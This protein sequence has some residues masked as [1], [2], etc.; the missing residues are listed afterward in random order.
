V[1]AQI[2][3]TRPG[4]LRNLRVIRTGRDDGS[5]IANVNAVVDGFVQQGFSAI[6]YYDVDG[7]VIARSGE[8]VRAPAIA[9]TLG[10]PHKAEL[11]W[12]GGYLMRHRIA[13]RD[14]SGDVGTGL[15]EQPLSVLNRVML[16]TPRL[17]ATAEIFQPVRE[18]LQLVAGLLLLLVAVGT[19][20]LRL[21]VRPLVT[22]LIDIGSHA[23][24]QEQRTKE[25]LDSAPD[26]IIIVNRDGRIVLVNS[27]TEKLFG[28]SRQE[29]LDQK[30]E[31][32][33]P[34]RYRQRHP[35]H[36]DG[37]FA[38]PRVRPMG[39]GLELYGR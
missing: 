13:L 14:T 10:T 39:V 36:R 7:K 11:L 33:L 19:V 4:V 8:F 26:A 16:D 2:A 24:R 3:A 27:Q 20:L 30:I 35:G 15:A 18:Q 29:L 23:R 31:M 1:T 21:Q 37:F 28:Y 38:D 34:E 25:L 6:A 17:G 5:N 9:V 12:N 22:K 32:L